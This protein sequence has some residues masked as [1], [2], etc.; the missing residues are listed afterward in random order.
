LNVKLNDAG[1]DEPESQKIWDQIDVCRERIRKIK[2][3][4]KK[5]KSAHCGKEHTAADEKTSPAEEAALKRL[6]EQQKV[7]EK[8]EKEKPGELKDVKDEELDDALKGLGKKS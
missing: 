1:G 6:K 3:E 7:W 5:S 4:L 8:E 2:E